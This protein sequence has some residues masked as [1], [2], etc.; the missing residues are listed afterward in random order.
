M[1]KILICA[2]LAASTAFSATAHADAFNGP[3]IGVDVGY[4]T[5]KVK[6]SNT[7]TWFDDYEDDRAQ[8]RSSY[9]GDSVDGFVGGVYAGY[10]MPIAANVFAG[11]EVRAS[12]SGAKFSDR[13]TNDWYGDWNTSVKAKESFSATARLGYLLNEKTALYVRGGVVQTRFKAHEYGDYYNNN[14]VSLAEYS[15]EGPSATVKDNN[16]GALF[17]AGLE[18][19]VGGNVMVRVEYNVTKY[20]KMFSKISR[21]LNY[22]DGDYSNITKFKGS[23]NQVRLGVSYLF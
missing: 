16:I 9:N 10:D 11:V 1:N 19:S 22:V 20:G 2:A 14:M 6:T 8:S 7:N 13:G 23:N 5:G 4:D 15:E 21:E 17:G 18:T 12:L 3:F